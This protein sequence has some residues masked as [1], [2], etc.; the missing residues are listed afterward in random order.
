VEFDPVLDELVVFELPT[1]HLAER[2]LTQLTP[3]RLAWMQYDDDSSVVAALLSPDRLDLAVLLRDVQAW[4]TRAGLGPIRFE[5]DGKTYLLHAPEPAL[6]AR[7]SAY[8]RAAR[9]RWRR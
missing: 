1:R 3:K 5:L 4:L 8:E 7:R 9:H 2:L 6:A